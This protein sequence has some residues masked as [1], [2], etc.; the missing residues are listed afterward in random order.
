MYRVPMLEAH[1]IHNLFRVDLKQF[2]QEDPHLRRAA[3][4]PF[5]YQSPLI[6]LPEW[7]HPGILML[8]GGRQVGKTTCLKQYIA[9]ILRENRIPARHVSFLAGELIRDDKELLRAISDELE[10][11][12][13]WSVI[14]VDEINY[15]RDWDKAIKFLAD[16][17]SLEETTVLLS[18]SDSVI[19]RDAMKRFAGRRGRSKQVDFVFHPLDFAETVEL[20]DPDFASYVHDK[21]IADASTQDI[22]DENS[23][24][25]LDQLFAE[26]LQHGGYLT[27]IADWKRE[28]E[29]HPSTYRTYAEWL[30]GDI[31]KHNRQEKYLFEILQGLIRTYATP[32][33]WQSLAKDMTI[34]HHK[35]VSDYLTI[36][37][38][39]HAV[40]IL[41]A[42]AEHT[43]RAAP[44]K[45]KKLYFYDPFIAHAVEAM[46]ESGERVDTAALVET[47]AV[48]HYKRRHK[49]V[50]YIKGTKGEVDVAYIE[51]QTIYP[52]EVKWTRQLRP[53]ELKQIMTYP[54]GIVL[55]RQWS[56]GSINQI[57][58]QSLLSHLMRPHQVLC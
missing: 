10:G 12:R 5:T 32:V 34:D 28:G 19:L 6:D 11:I 57:K 42:L 45:N 15:I 44:K 17:G 29:I 1:A 7:T 47:V 54:H 48:A 55:G 37:E 43:L 4:Q 13:G 56:N 8:T 58:V 3:K 40:I 14:V 22:L 18:G 33:S 36:L 9:R 2:E 53:A 46:L 25:R 16:A 24:N 31:L 26:F 27:A 50:F 49:D 20:K 21:Q 41:E 51:D 38:D 39:M 35:T 52:V 23:R 30:R